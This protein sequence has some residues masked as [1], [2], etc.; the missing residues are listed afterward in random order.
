MKH[1]IGVE[2]AANILKVGQGCMFLQLDGVMTKRGECDP[3]VVGWIDENFDR[4]T[5]TLGVGYDTSK[6]AAN[7]ADNVRQRLKDL[8]LVSLIKNMQKSYDA[9]TPAAKHFQQKFNQFVEEFKERG[10]SSE[11]AENASLAS[12]IFGRWCHFTFAGNG[13]WQ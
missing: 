6:G 2:L 3:I 7:S 9:D 11:D 5:V 4:Q 1:Q 13:Y 12:Y 8:N 10:M